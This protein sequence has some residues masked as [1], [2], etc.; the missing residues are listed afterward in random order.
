MFAGKMSTHVEINKTYIADCEKG[1]K[2]FDANGDGTVT[3]QEIKNFTGSLFHSDKL[4][5]KV[6]DKLE[7]IAE[8]G[9]VSADEYAYWVNSNEYSEGLDELN[10]RKKMLAL[11]TLGLH[12]SFSAAIKEYN[13][14]LEFR[15]NPTGEQKDG[16]KTFLEQVEN[17]KSQGLIQ[18]GLEFL[19]ELFG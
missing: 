5:A 17:K 7:T 9:I 16:V 12:E 4:D 18:R 1:L 14:A 11:G 10:S 15:T 13:Y 6:F 3:T 2:R 19:R 8:D